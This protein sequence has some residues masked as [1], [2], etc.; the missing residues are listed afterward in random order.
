[1]LPS[2]IL[3]RR[4]RSGICDH[5]AT[6]GGDSEFYRVAGFR[7]LRV[8]GAGWNCDASAAGGEPAMDHQLGAEKVDPFDDGGNAIGVVGPRPQMNMLR[9]DC[10]PL[11]L[12]R[13]NCWRR[14]EANSLIAVKRQR[15]RRNGRP[16]FACKPTAS[17]R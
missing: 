1:M 6:S 8:V 17:A 9:S 15:T 5:A 16:W 10:K 14:D 2:A 7:Y 3:I 13:S 11:R 4:L 12:D